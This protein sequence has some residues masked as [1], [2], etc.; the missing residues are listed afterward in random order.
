MVRSDLIIA[1]SNF[2]FN[3]IH[4]NYSYLIT[5]KKKLVVI[6]RGINTEYYNNVSIAHEK[7]NKFFQNLILTQKL[8][9]Y[10]YQEDLQGGKVRRCL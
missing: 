7:I 9:K 6:F 3:H 1:G 10:Y 2:I 8:S 4:K 5:A